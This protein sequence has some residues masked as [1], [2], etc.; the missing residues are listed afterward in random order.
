[1]TTRSKKQINADVLE[2]CSGDDHGLW[3]LWWH[4]S[5]EIPA[6]ELPDLKNRFLNDLSDL[7]AEGKLI[8]KCHTRMSLVS[9]A[10]FTILWTDRLANLLD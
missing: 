2:L 7:V 10:Y 9:P 4:I 5:A 6:N 8:A 3:E 1:M